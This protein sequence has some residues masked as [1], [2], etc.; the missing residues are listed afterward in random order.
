VAVVVLFPAL[1]VVVEVRFLLS[2]SFL[3]NKNEGGIPAGGTLV[4]VR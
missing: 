1:I 3:A 2:G 4:T